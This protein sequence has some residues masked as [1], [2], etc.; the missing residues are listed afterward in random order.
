MVRPPPRPCDLPPGPSGVLVRAQAGD[1]PPRHQAGQHH[2][3]P[4]RSRRHD[5]RARLRDR[6]A[7]QPRRGGR[8]RPHQ[9]RR[10]PGLLSA[11]RRARTDRLRPHR[12]V[13]RRA[14]A[15]PHPDRDADRAA[16]LPG[17]RHAD[18]RADHGHRAADAASHGRRRRCLGAG[19]SQAT[20]ALA[21]R[22][23]EERRRAAGRPRDQLRPTEDGAVMAGIRD[24][25]SAA[26]IPAPPPELRIGQTMPLPPE[27][28]PQPTEPR[29]AKPKTSPA[30]RR[31]GRR[32][33]GAGARYVTGDFARDSAGRAT[34]GFPSRSRRRP[35]RRPL[36]RRRPPRSPSRWPWRPPRRRTPRKR[37]AIWL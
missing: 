28:P 4:E 17:E 23:L 1:C 36:A 11:L 16:A 13:D 9:D 2:G 12:P 20:R 31:R 27:P 37:S 15:G 25:S 5:A 30:H 7:G 22:A 33:A 29:P 32:P 34:A 19:A 18:L 35:P 10:H 6:Q 14:R 3:C 21:E 24:V 8:D 26:R